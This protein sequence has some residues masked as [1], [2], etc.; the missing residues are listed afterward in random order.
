MKASRPFRERAAT[1]SHEPAGAFG[2]SRSA[3]PPAL[4]GA[5]MVPDEELAKEI[6][7]NV[8]EA[9][10]SLHSLRRQ[11]YVIAGWARELARRLASGSR[12]LVAGNG[13]PGA[14]AQVR[15]RAR[16]G[17]VVLL[18]S[19]N[20]RSPRLVAAARTAHEL[21]A[22]TWA[23]TGPTPNPLAAAVDEVVALEGRNCHV[24]EAQLVGLH[25]LRECFEDCVAERE[26]R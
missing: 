1:R 13:A 4:A 20:G 14:E 18:L 7:A 10:E 5:H 9:E 3:V 12:L 26:E 19:T 25:A 21:G 2:A 11:S 17:D 15:A 23:F 8:G 6:E 16:H 22:R 24:E